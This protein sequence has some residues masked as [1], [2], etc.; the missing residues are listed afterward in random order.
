MQRF[1]LIFQLISS[2]S[3]NILKLHPRSSK[4]LSVSVLLI[5]ENLKQ[6]ILREG[7]NFRNVCIPQST[8]AITWRDGYLIHETQRILDLEL[9]LC[10]AFLVLVGLSLHSILQRRREVQYCGPKVG[11]GTLN[12][13]LSWLVIVQQI[14][15]QIILRHN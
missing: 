13:G 1:L 9:I 10:L 15:P 14:I 2:F 5:T 3:S 8:V 12:Q 4:V 6:R 11:N 7:R